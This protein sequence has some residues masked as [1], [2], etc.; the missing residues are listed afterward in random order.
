MILWP[1]KEPD[2]WVKEPGAVGPNRLTFREFYG[3]GPAEGAGQP[4]ELHVELLH[5]SF[6]HR[7]AVRGAEMPE[8]SR[9]CR[10]YCPLAGAL[11]Y[12][13]IFSSCAALD[14]PQLLPVVV[15]RCVLGDVVQT[16]PLFS[17]SF[18]TLIVMNNHCV[19]SI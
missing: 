1:R 17:F 9:S 11:I 6:H 2:I 3:P 12:G 18:L 8:C 7:L 10:P 13:L 19:K 14:S 16:L 15:P 4:A 5:R